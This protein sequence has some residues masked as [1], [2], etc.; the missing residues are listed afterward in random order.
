M[1][2]LLAPD[3]FKG[4]LSALDVARHL[5]AGLQTN[6]PDV[7][8]TLAPV[9]DGLTEALIASLRAANLD[10]VSRNGVLPFRGTETQVDSIAERLEA[11]RSSPVTTCVWVPTTTLTLPS[12]YSPSAFFSEVSS[13]WKSTRR[14]G[15]SGSGDDDSSSSASASVKGFSMG[16]M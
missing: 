5:A 4:S 3:K 10:V 7:E 1:R 12:R 2:V 15:G 6:S 16:C 11:W 13:Q 14:I 9:A 8:V